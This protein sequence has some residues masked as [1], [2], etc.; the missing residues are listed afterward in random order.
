MSEGNIW[1]V[2]WSL[3]VGSS[4]W[5]FIILSVMSIIFLQ[6]RYFDK[7][8][9]VCPSMYTR[10]SNACTATATKRQQLLAIFLYHESSSFMTRRMIS[11]DAPFYMK[12]C[13]KVTPYFKKRQ[14]PIDIRS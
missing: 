2:N 5:I 9:S 1:S 14:F 8:L 12:F 13:A 3:T 10:L 7:H 6:P 4:M 11:G